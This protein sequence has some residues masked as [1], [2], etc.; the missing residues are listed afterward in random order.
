M[1]I[2]FLQ[3]LFQA[4]NFGVV[5]GAITFL[6]YKPVMK[7]LDERAKKIAEGQSAAEKS[8]RERRDRSHEEKSQDFK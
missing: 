4:I 6:L 7:M 3:I 8:I 1:E 5:F 2:N